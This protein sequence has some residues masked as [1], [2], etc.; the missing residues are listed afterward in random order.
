MD[1]RNAEGSSTTHQERDPWF[2]P[3]L[4]P[5]NARGH[6]AV[7]PVVRAVEN[8]GRIRKLKPQDRYT[9]YRV[10]IPV[11]SNLIHHYLIGSPGKGYPVPRSHRDKALGGKVNRY[12]PFSFPR[13]FPKMLDALVALGFAEQTIGKSLKR[14]RTTVKA[15]P[16]LIELIKEHKIALEDLSVSNHQEI[17]ILKRRKRGH[18]DGG[19]RLDYVDTPVTKR[20]RE[21]LRAINGALATADIAFDRA[22]YQFPVDVQA[23][24]LRR[25][26]TGRFDSGGR[27]FGGFW[28][29]LKRDVR[30]RGIRIEG[31]AVVGLDYSQ[32]NPLLAYY[33]AGAEPPSGDAYTLPGLEESRD[34]VKKVFNA[35][36]FKH[37]LEKLPKGSRKLFPKRI[38]CKDV[39]EAILS[40]H[41]KLKGAL[42]STEIGHH[43]QFLEGKIMMGVLLKCLKWNIIALPIFDSV[44][45]KSSVERTVEKI[46]RQEF[47]AVAGLNVLVK[48]ELPCAGTSQK[49]AEE[50]AKL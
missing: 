25:H 41:P 23:R 42:S 49:L 35:M 38:K 44:I 19:A 43:L 24:Q 21:E 15:G 31:E 11:V 28:E 29:N 2:N 13:S 5:A 39:T 46:M 12:Q 9:L 47:K 36:L 18:W 22:T 26:F 27:L 32:V 45:V 1:T 17:I 34:G 8:Y 7:V 33:V 37:P 10:L 6:A 20:F 48:R 16:K 4:S 50:A 3:H 40:R 14:K 30:L